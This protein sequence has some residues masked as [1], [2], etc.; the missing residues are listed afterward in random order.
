MI[1][2]M[3]RA[4]FQA[5]SRRIDD[6][7]LPS[8]RCSCSDVLR[9]RM[10]MKH[11]VMLLVIPCLWGCASPWRYWKSRA[12]DLWDV[13][14]VS[15][16]K[17]GGLSASAGVTPFVRTGLGFYFSTEP[18]NS[19]GMALGRWG[20]V[21]KEN[22]YHFLVATVEEQE[23]E[24]D[25]WPGGP[26]GRYCNPDEKKLARSRMNLLVVLPVDPDHEA[27]GHFA[28][29]RFPPWYSWLDSEA[30]VFVLFFG[31]RVGVS[32]LQLVDFLAGF[33]GLDPLGDD[34]PP[35]PAEGSEQESGSGEAGR[36]H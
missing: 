22:G 11:F 19:Y 32:P 14:P 3:S 17:G 6:R 5:R 4:T 36:S 34:V 8:T 10:A 9:W 2:G 20:P 30:E 26:D 16:Q 1:P 18:P 29:V 35:R 21:W 12:L 23:L 25:P 24:G 27:G 13:L 15:V 31:I 28:R 7:V 33:L